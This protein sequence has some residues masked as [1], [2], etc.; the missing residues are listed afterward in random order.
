VGLAPFAIVL[1]LELAFKTPE[2]ED[3]NEDDYDL[4]SE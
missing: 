4:K 3:D 1:V 2:Y